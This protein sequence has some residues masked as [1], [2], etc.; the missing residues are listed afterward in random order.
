M[1]VS[2]FVLI[3][4]WMTCTG[5]SIGLVRS[6]GGASVCRFVTLS[7][8]TLVALTFELLT[9]FL[10]SA[11]IR[12]LIVPDQPVV[13]L[14]MTTPSGRHFLIHGMIEAEGSLLQFRTNGYEQCPL[15]SPNLPA[16]L[17][18]LNELNHRLRLVKFTLDPADGEII[19]FS[20]LAL[21]DSEPT[22]GQVLGLI[23][24]VMERLR[25]YADRIEA[26]VQTGIDPGEVDDVIQ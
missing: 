4:A 26:T 8:S 25:E 23:A 9:S 14:G 12:Y 1:A 5:Y 6:A 20:D 2:R 18:L 10:K 21:L 24:F 22:A 17:L 7:R 11:E 15:T 16:V 19:V 13:A 3:V